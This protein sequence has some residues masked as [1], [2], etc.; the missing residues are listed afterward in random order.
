M[1]NTVPPD[2]TSPTAPPSPGAMSTKEK[3]DTLIGFLQTLVSWPVILLVVLILIRDQIPDMAGRIESIGPGG[4]ELAERV[5]QLEATQQQAV[6]TQQILEQEVEQI[7]NAMEF[8]PGSA[9]LPELEANLLKRVNDHREYLETVGFN[10]GGEPVQVRITRD[11]EFGR[12]AFYHPVENYIYLSPELATDPELAMYA[13]TEY[14][15]SATQPRVEGAGS[16]DADYGISSGLADYFTCSSSGDP[17]LAEI[18]TPPLGI[19]NLDN[20]MTVADI[21]DNPLNA[22]HW[23]YMRDVW[24][25]A[26][27]EL[28]SLL[29]AD[30]ADR[31]LLVAWSGTDRMTV[32][33]STFVELI[34]SAAANDG[35]PDLS[36]EIWDLFEDRGLPGAVVATPVA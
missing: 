23:F 35:G 9:L 7:R 19:R 27:W 4:I 24:N 17:R 16:K 20:E 11:L 6:A 21:S 28:R 5:Q 26:F 8:E 10:L 18:S 33:P 12:N 2:G 14:A 25:G 13:Y 29:G 31:V 34:I 36:A 15:L 32:S 30:R 3:L 1:A 22:P